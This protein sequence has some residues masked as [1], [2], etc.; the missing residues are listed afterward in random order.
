MNMDEILENQRLIMMALRVLL[1]EQPNQT[2]DHYAMVC[3]LESRISEMP[4]RT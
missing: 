4:V 1:R 2:P 3:S